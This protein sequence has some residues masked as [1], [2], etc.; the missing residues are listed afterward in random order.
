M[1]GMKPPRGFEDPARQLER[2]QEQM[3]R[4]SCSGCAHWMR[5]WDVVVCKK[6]AGRTGSQV[7]PCN[8]FVKKKG[9]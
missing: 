5:L 1:P 9:S 2:M 4:R 3:Q 8:D 7:H 6:H